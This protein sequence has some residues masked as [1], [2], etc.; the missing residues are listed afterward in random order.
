MN[1]SI[2]KLLD[3]NVGHRRAFASPGLRRIVTMA[4]PPHLKSYHVMS[5]TW[6]GPKLSIAVMA[7]LH[8][9]APWTSLTA[10]SR[11]AEL[12]NTLNAD[13][14]VL[15]GDYLAEAKLPGNRATATQIFDALSALD[16]P[17]GVFAV[18]GNHDWADCEKAKKSNY[19]ENS[20]VDALQKSS[21]HLLQNSNQMIEHMG[22]NFWIVGLDSQHPAPGRPQ[23]VHHDPDRAYEGVP[24]G[25]DSILVAHEPDYFAAQDHRSALQISGHTHGGQANLFGWRPIV[26]SRFGARYAYGHFVDE[27]RQ[28][29]VS[30]GMGYSGVPMRIG[31]PP[32][33]NLINFGR[34]S[35]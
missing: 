10:L 20:V 31:Q 34:L 2:G 29:I 15:A 14:I 6:N 24:D 5:D 22:A 25:A 17:L 7:D 32:E 13:I 26:P 30:G 33:V 19:T 4:G 3:K 27:N 9:V 8:V 16:A 11:T 28:M 18:L 12:V 1:K 23:I 35:T 21:F